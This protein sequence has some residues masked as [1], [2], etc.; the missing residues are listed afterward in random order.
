MKKNYQRLHCSIAYGE[1]VQPS[2]IIKGLNTSASVLYTAA[3]QDFAKLF[4]Y[5]ST[6]DTKLVIVIICLAML[7]VTH[8]AFYTVKC[9][10]HNINHGYF[11]VCM[12]C[13]KTVTHAYIEVIRKSLCLAKHKVLRSRTFNYRCSK[14]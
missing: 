3:E 12:A 1:Q 11:G 14:S 6:M 2:N 9:F 4:T 10:L 5:Y 13:R 7:N 8:S